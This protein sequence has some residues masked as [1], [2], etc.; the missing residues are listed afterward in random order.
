MDAY[1]PYVS[2]AVALGMGLIVGLEREQ[3]STTEEPDSPKGLGGART[4]PLFAL[5]GGVASLVARE[6]GAWFVALPLVGLMTLAAIAYR[7]DV[8]HGRDRGLTSETAFVLTY[9]LGALALIEGIFE[10]RA[11]RLITV[12]SIGVVATTLLSMK[13]PLHG[14]VRQV[15]R[16]DLFATLEFLIVAVIAL[17]LI[18]NTPLGPYGALN[19]FHIGT[20]VVL[21]AG[22]SFVG[23]VAI[24]VLGAGRGLG[25]TGLI[26]GLVSSTAVTLS[27]AARAKEDPSVRQACTLA[28]LLASSIMPARIL[29][30]V[31]I[32]YPPLV[33]SLAFPLGGMI[34]G[35]AVA[36]AFLYLETRKA[37]PTT[38]RAI[39][40]RNPFELATAIKFGVFF[41][42]V[43]VISKAA[44]DYFGEQGT[45]LAGLLA[46]TTD[47]DAISLSMAEL[48]RQ[49]LPLEVS[50]TAILLAA[51]SNTLVKA[52]LALGAGGAAFAYRVALG[53]LLSLGLGA[54]G[55]LIL[56]S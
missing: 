10:T 13:S 16:S 23:Y 30:A 22:M 46:G 31:A 18:P 28:V 51:S 37:P 36:A 8:A 25:L 3:A 56:W 12:S 29:I 20:M 6:L 19:P 27:M 45:Y 53:L 17:P 26:G 44:N 9:L 42:A 39:A 47:V 49:G 4:F 41:A 43:M 33:S 52:G 32:V 55:L 2:L 1:E 24:R 34:A 35:A 38:A 5:T 21:I 40:V 50:A 48:A 11:Q 54:G 14:F 15:S 7:D